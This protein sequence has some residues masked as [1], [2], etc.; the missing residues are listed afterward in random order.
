MKRCSLFVIL[1]IGLFI[2]SAS[3][4][5]QAQ[6]QTK[7]KAQKQTKSQAQK[8]T[9]AQAQAQPTD[10]QRGKV[11]EILSSVP[12]VDG[13]NDVPIQYRS[14]VGNKL[15]AMDFWNTRALSRPM[16]TDIERLKKGQ[17]GAQFW[18]VFVSANQP[19]QQ[20]L[21][22]TMEQI[23]FVYRLVD[24]YPNE[25]GIALTADQLEKQFK[26]KRIASLIGIE[27]GHSI[28]NSLGAL[29]QFYALG[30]RYMTL[31]HS[32][33]LD[34]ADSATDSVRHGGLTPFGR[35]VVREMNR[36]GMLVDISHVSPAVMSHALDVTEAPVIFSHS[37]ARAVCDHVRNVPDSILVRVKQNK[38]IVMV[39][40]VPSYLNE[41]LR[42]HLEAAEAESNRLKAAHA[43]DATAIEEG[44]NRWRTANPEPRATLADVADH[45]DHIR[46]LIGSEYI[47]IGGDYDGIGSLPLGLEDVGTYPD[48]F[49]ELLRRGYTEQELK[50]IAGLN[51]L[52]VMREVERVAERLQTQ[53][54]PSEM[55]FTDK[56]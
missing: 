52:R 51:F 32:R 49:A 22:Q 23:D 36:L 47:G 26:A 19:E 7:P 34:W 20:A 13:H 30:A 40:F 27:G 39:T 3:I 11:K 45:I 43:N 37:S 54:G 6:P 14:R 17:V 4:V 29:R 42:R 28:A 33:S 2:Q 48:L 21:Q 35:E 9:K 38:G 18:S 24:K 56:P 15:S 50:N 16:H 5:A 53:R 41:N 46:K 44:M 25:F 55:L 31:T 8:P 10:A 12:L 1:L